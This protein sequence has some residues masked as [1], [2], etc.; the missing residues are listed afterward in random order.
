MDELLKG[1]E[2]MS[3]WCEYEIGMGILLGVERRS[4]TKNVL[5]SA[6]RAYLF[7]EDQNKIGEVG[8]CENEKPFDLFHFSTW[9]RSWV[10]DD[11]TLIDAIQRLEKE[12]RKIKY[13][14]RFHCEGINAL[15][16]SAIGFFSAWVYEI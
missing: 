4:L 9:R 16:L 5:F 2:K 11:E 3:S 14:V 6:Q 13:V 7:D 1:L 15:E 12:N 10:I 8:Y